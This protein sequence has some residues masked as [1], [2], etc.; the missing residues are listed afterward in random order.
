LCAISQSEKAADHKG[1]GRERREAVILLAVGQSE[2]SKNNE[3]PEEEGQ[4]GFI[5]SSGRVGAA[6]EDVDLVAEG[7]REEDRP[8][9]DPEDEVEPEEP[10]GGEAVVV[11]DT[12]G[13]EA[14]DVLVIE[15]EPC[16]ASG[17]REAEAC[18]EC[19]CRGA[20]GGEDV[21]GGGEG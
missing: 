13:E 16:P 1:K 2:E 5:L 12:F 11:G 20:K 18:W 19:D 7:A 6:A 10:D 4:R 21:P 17:C 14:G 8:R 9:H 15:I 3:C